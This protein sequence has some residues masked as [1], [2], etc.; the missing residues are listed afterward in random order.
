MSNVTLEEHVVMHTIGGRAL[1]VDI[2]RPANPQGPVPGLLFLPGGGWQTANRAPLMER[3]GVRMAQHGLVCVTGEYRVMDEAPWPAQIQDVK[4]Q[5]RWMRAQSERLGIDPAAIVVGGKS[6]GGHLAL[7]AAGTRGVDAFEGDSGN[8]GVSSEVA[9]VIG[10]A[11]VS[12][13][14][15]WARRPALA[16]L[17]GENP[18]AE[19]VRAASPVTYANGDYPPTLFVHGTSDTR[20]PHGMTM[21]MY[22]ALEQA[23]VPVDLYLLAG[24]DHFFDQEPQFSAAVA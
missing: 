24:Q 2:C 1:T 4:A 22:Q 7:L 18:S 17:F 11:P 16:R 6:A 5:I 14:T 20:V 13:V 21:R 10:V 9:A 12:D 15:E 8:T 23:G 3:Y 19:T